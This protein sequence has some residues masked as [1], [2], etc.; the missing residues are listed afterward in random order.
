M[1]YIIYE[2]GTEINRIVASEDFVTAYCAENGYT[3]EAIEPAP[4]PEPE[5]TLEERVTNIENAIERGLSDMGVLSGPRYRDIPGH[6]PRRQRMVHLLAAPPWDKPGDGPALCAGAGEPRHV[7]AGR[8]HGL[9]GRLDLPV[10]ERHQFQPGRVPSGM[11]GIR[12]V[13]G[14]ELWSPV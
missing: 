9:H 3:Y 5:S 10:Q 2:N 1:N 14:S 13:R 8:V 4:E 6:Y 11:G 12:W 7:P